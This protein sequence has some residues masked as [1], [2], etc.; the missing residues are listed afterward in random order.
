MALSSAALA[1]APANMPHENKAIATHAAAFMYFLFI[2]I[3]KPPFSI[4]KFLR[5]D[6][7]ASRPATAKL[8]FEAANCNLE[9]LDHGL[10]RC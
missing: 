7:I 6:S 5:I 4:D 9:K 1:A 10:Y 3:N 2:I 8:S